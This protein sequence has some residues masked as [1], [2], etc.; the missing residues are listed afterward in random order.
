MVTLENNTTEGVGGGVLN[1]LNETQQNESNIT[2][3]KDATT[4]DTTNTATAVT[5]ATEDE[6]LVKTELRK[7]NNHRH[8][9][10]SGT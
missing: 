2:K 3:V 6:D 7:V 9:N 10:E 8:S 4:L 1:K 5:A